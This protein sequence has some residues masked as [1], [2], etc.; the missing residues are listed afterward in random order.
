MRSYLIL[1]AATGATLLG[2][3]LIK[4]AGQTAG[5]LL[6]REFGAGLVLYSLP[7]VGW[8]YLMKSHSLALIGVTYS[9]STI[10]LLAVLGT[11]VFKEQFGLRETVGVSLA[12]LSVVTMS[13]R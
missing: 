7:A 2:D 9:V 12:L 10:V 4:L 11:F 1:L 3:Y 8:F 13:A 5:G 6:S